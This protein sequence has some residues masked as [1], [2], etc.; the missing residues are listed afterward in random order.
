MKVVSVLQMRELDRLTIEAGTPDHQ[1]MFQAAQAAFY[2]LLPWLRQRPAATVHV[3]V[4]VGANGGDGL[5][6]A[7]L[8]HQSGFTVQVYTLRDPARFLGASRFH[9]QVLPESVPVVVGQPPSWLPQGDVVIDALLGTGFHGRLNDAV[10]PW[11]QIANQAPV[12]RI[13]IDVPSGLNADNGD[14]DPDTFCADLTVTLALPKR[15]LLTPDAARYL[16]ILRVVAIGIPESLIQET[17]SG[18]ELITA[19]DVYHAFHHKRAMDS[20]KKSFGSVLILAGSEIYSGA[21]A[22][23]AEAAL[24]SGC[25]YVHWAFPQGMTQKRQTNA[26]IYHPLSGTKG[27]FDL[28]MFNQASQII[29]TVSVVLFGPGV[30]R[31]LPVG[32]FLGH[33][34]QQ[35][36]PLVLDAD[37]LWLLA[38]LSTR[39][40]FR[41]FAVLTPHP[42]EFR[43]L[44]AAFLSPEERQ[45]TEAEQAMRLAQLLNAVI[46]LKGFRTLVVTPGGDYWVNSSGNWGLATAGSGDV[47]A[48]MIA[49]FLAESLQ[50]GNFSPLEAVLSAVYI[51]GRLAELPTVNRRSLIADDLPGLIGSVFTELGL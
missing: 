31:K 7:R 25:G 5:V 17:A 6:L 2:E 23:T 18:G 20:H 38:E 26:L 28:K 49:A 15:G 14:L 33:L 13:A 8:L 22:L 29:Q 11:L 4:G 42:G 44:S 9:W 10:R 30:G 21:G 48:G 47:L 1:L 19:A 24:R 35:P 27:F 51:H 3:L 40:V 36:T 45:K 43:R 41:Q 34:I 32:E 12:F 50:T 37:G 46:V 16:G 39:P